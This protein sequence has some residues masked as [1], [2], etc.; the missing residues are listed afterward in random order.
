MKLLVLVLCCGLLTTVQA[1]NE[2]DARLIAKR[3][4]KTWYQ[5]T[6]TTTVVPLTCALFTSTNPCRRRRLR[7]F[8]AVKPLGKSLDGS[9]ELTGTLSEGKSIGELEE[10]G[11]SSGRGLAITFVTTTTSTYTVTSQSINS[12]TTFSLSFYC[13]AANA[14]IPPAC[15]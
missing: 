1:V 11:D 12:S 5:L 8:N 4:T 2:D 14:V 10:G 6:T 9:A 7:R 13:S 15:G 3:T